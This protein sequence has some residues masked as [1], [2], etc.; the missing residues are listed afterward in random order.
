MAT[1]ST[2]MH[3]VGQDARLWMKA[4]FGVQMTRTIS[5]CVTMPTTNQPGWDRA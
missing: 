4:T 3:R 5:V 1:I 2:I